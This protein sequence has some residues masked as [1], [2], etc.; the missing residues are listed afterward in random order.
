MDAL[1]YKFMGL[2]ID[3]FFAGFANEGDTSVIAKFGSQICDPSF[4]VR[5]KFGC[6]V[7]NV[8]RRRIQRSDRVRNETEKK[9]RLR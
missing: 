1:F 5:V 6:F 2:L 4:E 3:G 9:R 7:S 8:L